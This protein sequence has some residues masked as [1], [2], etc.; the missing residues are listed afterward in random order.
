MKEKSRAPH[1]YVPSTLGQVLSLLKREPKAL[2]LAGGTYILTRLN[3]RFSSL[4][5]PIIYLGNVEELTNIGRTDQFLEIGACVSIR[6]TLE[7]GK[8]LLPGILNRALERLATP[9]IK[10]RAT[11]GGN[12]CVTDKRMDSY[13]VLQLLN[14]MVELRSS[15]SS[16]WI[17]INKLID[18]RGEVAMN[19]GE[20]LTRLRIPIEQWDI[21][22]YRKIG[23]LYESGGNQ[24]SFCALART[25]K[26]VINEFTFAFGAIGPAVL[27]D[28]IIE[29]ELSGKKL[30]LSER[31]RKY[32]LD[33][34]K[35][36]VDKHSGQVN[37]FQRTRIQ[38]IM[39]RFLLKLTVD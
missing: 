7:L 29:A 10:N 24:L 14:V 27:R 19:E 3:N 5:G 2:L 6:H 33:L 32:I 17:P 12:I 4:P 30:P 35:K 20:L 25:Q 38:Q 39:R 26:G 36:A 16:R 31:E 23:S 15:N 9:L 11:I 21:Q 37:E 28:R 8:N 34:L 22:E 1:A 18:E 13:P